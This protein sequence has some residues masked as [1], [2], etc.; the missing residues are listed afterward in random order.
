MPLKENEI[1]QVKQRIGQGRAGMRKSRLPPINQTIALSAESSRKI[2]EASEIEKKVINHPDFTTSVHSINNS[3]AE[4]INGKPMTKG[5]PSP[6]PVR[7][8]TSEGP[9]NIDIIPK[10]NIDFKKN[11]KE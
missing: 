2:P 4:V 3:Y 1:S 7:I 6:K 11:F 10:L 5:R 8:S 9:E